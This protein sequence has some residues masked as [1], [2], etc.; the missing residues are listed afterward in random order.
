[1]AEKPEKQKEKEGIWGGGAITP[2]FRPQHQHRAALRPAEGEEPAGPRNTTG[3][4]ELLGWV[5]QARGHLRQ[6]EACGGIL[7]R[8]P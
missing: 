1:M 6:Q 4:S 2:L 8:E 5:M 7:R 3:E